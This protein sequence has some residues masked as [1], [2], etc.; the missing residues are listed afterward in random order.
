MTVRVHPGVHP[1]RTAD[2]PVR[3]TWFHRIL[4]VLT[5]FGGLFGTY[6]V[7]V[8]AFTIP[9]SATQVPSDSLLLYKITS[10][11]YLA[12]HSISFTLMDPVSPT[13]YTLNVSLIPGWHS[14]LYVLA[15]LALMIAGYWTGRRTY[16]P[17]DRGLFEGMKLAAVYAPIMFFLGLLSRYSGALPAQQAGLSE[18][19]IITDITGVLLIAGILYPVVFAGLGGAL[20]A[21]V[22]RYLDGRSRG[23]LY[24]L[25]QL[26]M[27][28]DDR[29]AKSEPAPGTGDWTSSFVGGVTMTAAQLPGFI[30]TVLIFN[31]RLYRGRPPLSELLGYEVL[32]GVFLVGGLGIGTLVWRR[33][34]RGGTLPTSGGIGVGLITG[35]AVHILFWVVVYVT[36]GVL[37][38]DLGLLRDPALILVLTFSTGWM[39][40]VGAVGGAVLYLSHR[41]SVAGR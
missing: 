27:R 5:T 22:E 21:T 16:N 40:S 1:L 6:L 30:I 8:A 39:Q 34:S 37:T 24:R 38:L 33:V 29:Q 2:D 10:W 18:G 11:F 17:E 23:P 28:L 31:N 13:E 12:S 41:S 36:T 32:F 20:P 3:N 25:D 19:E 9:R 7:V 4:V 14:V 26:L 35:T 15:P